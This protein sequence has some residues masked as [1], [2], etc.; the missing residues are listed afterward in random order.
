MARI[1]GFGRIGLYPYSQTS[2][3]EKFALGDQM[4]RAVVSISSNIAEGQSRAS[5][6]EYIH[7][8]YIAKG[9]NAEIYTQLLLGVR[10]GYFTDEQVKEPIELCGR[11][12]RMLNSLITSLK[13]KDK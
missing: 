13:N 6:K 3:E 8:S 9:S 1:H 12:Q 7:F 11:I 10:L 4:R 2:P 5:T